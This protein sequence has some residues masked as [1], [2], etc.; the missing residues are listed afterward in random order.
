LQFPATNAL[1]HGWVSVVMFGLLAGS[2]YY[3]ARKPL[4]PNEI[5]TPASDEKPAGEHRF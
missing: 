1:N 4:A 5:V 2:L 3:F